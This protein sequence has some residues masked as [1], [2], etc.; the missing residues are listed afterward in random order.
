MKLLALVKNPAIIASTLATAGEELEMQ[1][2]SPGRGPP[3]GIAACCA[4][5]RSVTRRWAA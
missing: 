4:G 3:Y 2:R 5:R 1:Q